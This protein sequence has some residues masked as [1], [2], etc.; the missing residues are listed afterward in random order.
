MDF[1]HSQSTKLYRVVI[2]EGFLWTLERE[3]SASKQ[4]SFVCAWFFFYLT[5]WAN[6]GL[7]KRIAPVQNRSFR[8][9]FFDLPVGKVNCKFNSPRNYEVLNLSGKICFSTIG[10][11][12]TFLLRNVIYVLFLKLVRVNKMFN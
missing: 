8:L 6:F 12:V 9:F 3:D 2:T 7:P 5:K 10:Q 11:S 4:V 1:T